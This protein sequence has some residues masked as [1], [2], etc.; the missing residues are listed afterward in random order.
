MFCKNTEH[1]RWLLLNYCN[2]RRHRLLGR[3]TK[4]PL[5]NFE[6]KKRWKLSNFE[7]P[8]KFLVTLVAYTKKSA[9]ELTQ[10][11]FHALLKNGQTH[12]TDLAVGTPQGFKIM[13]GHFS[14]WKD[15]WK[16]LMPMLPLYRNQAID[17]YC[18]SS[19]RFLYNGKIVVYEVDILNNWNDSLFT[20]YLDRG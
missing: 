4:Q 19:V 17:L 5:N 13:F 10:L 16:G 20:F 8:S 6:P 2:S 18:T 7:Q 11:P 3:A 9:Y 15:S 14:A 12:F 1:L